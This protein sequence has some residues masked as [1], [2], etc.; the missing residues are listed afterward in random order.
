[1]RPC[2]NREFLAL[3]GIGH[4]YADV[5]A[6]VTPFQNCIDRRFGCDTRLKQSRYQCCF[7]RHFNTPC[8]IEMRPE[9]PRGKP[10]IPYPLEM[11]KLCA[12]RLSTKADIAISR[13]SE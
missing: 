4:Q 6:R 10:D 7:I 3:C 9:P 1:M 8:E 13:N 2:L 12:D 5:F 11:S